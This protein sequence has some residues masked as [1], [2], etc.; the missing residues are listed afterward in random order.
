MQMVMDTYRVASERPEERRGA[1][2]SATDAPSELK[3]RERM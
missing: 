3:S 1:K 2:L